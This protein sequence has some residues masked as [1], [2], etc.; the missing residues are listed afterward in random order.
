MASSTSVRTATPVPPLPAQG[1]ASSSQAVPAISRCTQGVSPVNSR[2][3]HAAVDAPAPPAADVLNIGDGALDLVAI[4]V[5]ERHVP[6]LLA[7]RFGAGQH[8]LREGLVGA[9]DAAIDGA[10][11]DDDGSG[12]RGGIDQMRGAELLGIGDSVG[13]DQAALRRRC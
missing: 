2:R 13:E 9:E 3:N 11:R 5:V 6:H 1:L 8:P 10:E 12:Q 7:R 4:V